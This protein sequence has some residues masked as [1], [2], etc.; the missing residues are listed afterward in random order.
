M[1]KTGALFPTIQ[2]CANSYEVADGSEALMI[3][4]E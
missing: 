1:E 4:T 3:V 2:Y